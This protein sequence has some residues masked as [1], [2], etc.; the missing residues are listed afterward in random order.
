MNLFATAPPTRRIELPEAARTAPAGTHALPPDSGPLV[1]VV[2]QRTLEVF[3]RAVN[4]E[5]VTELRDLWLGRVEH[6]LGH[7]STRAWQAE[8]WRSSTA[9]R[10]IGAEEVLSSRATVRLVKE[11]F[12]FYFREDLYGDLRKDVRHILSGGSVDEISWGL[13]EALKETMR[14]ALDRDWYGYSDSCGR[15]PPRQAVAAYE[16]ARIHGATYT[17]DNVALTMGGTSAV[18]SMADFILTGRHVGG[19]PAL[20][21]IPNYPPLVESVARRAAVKLVPLGTENGVMS[22]DALIDALTPRTPL[23]LLQTA[24]NPTGAAVDEAELARLIRAASPSTLILLDE[25]HEWLGEPRTMSSQRAAPHVVRIS[26]LSKNWSAPGIKA[27]WIVADKSFIA[28]YYEYASTSFG[29]PPSFLYTTIEVL[30]R[31]ERWMITGVDRVGAEELGEFETSYALRRDQLQ[32]AYDSYRQDRGDREAA[33]RLLRDA[34]GT[35]LSA[36]SHVTRPEYSINTMVRFGQ[37]DDSYLCFRELLRTAGV[38]VYP[39]ILNFWFDSAI[40]R[41]TTARP[42]EDLEPAFHRLGSAI[43]ESRPAH[44]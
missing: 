37:W 44:V 28:D 1:P 14:Y 16:S 34:S 3:R 20:C 24:A 21:A 17:A 35:R 15:F 22:V 4:P 7:H 10:G 12:N 42:W 39:G 11:L 29:G 19:E 5:D 30:A 25:C 43:G 18:S 9:R 6:E 40:A 41:V 23:V 38:S 32:A 33:L 13:P 36:F 31:M 26:S 27:G 8:L 2:D